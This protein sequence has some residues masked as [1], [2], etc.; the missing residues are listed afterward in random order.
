[1]RFLTIL[2]SERW[3]LRWR[4]QKR[5]GERGA[6]WQRWTTRL[7]QPRRTRDILDSRSEMGQIELLPDFIFVCASPR[8]ISQR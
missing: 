4:N 3:R 2:T 5:P 7:C 6:D 8:S 1:M